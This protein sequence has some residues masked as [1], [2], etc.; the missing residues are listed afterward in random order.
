MDAEDQRRRIKAARALG[1]YASAAALA[2]DLGPGLSDKTLRKIESAGDPRV[3]EPHEL[4]AIARACRIDPAFFTIDLAD[5]SGN[6]GGEVAQLERR[7]AKLEELDEVI[8]RDLAPLAGL[9]PVRLAELV[10]EASPA[11]PGDTKRTPTRR[12]RAR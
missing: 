12:R 2:N 9:D 3:A 1:G 7:I 10:D 11:Q 8:R 6:G 5:L 4:D